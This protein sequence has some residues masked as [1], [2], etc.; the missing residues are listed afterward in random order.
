MGG[1][2]KWKKRVLAS[3]ETEGDRVT[4]NDWEEIASQQ[5]GVISRPSLKYEGQDR[6]EGAE[7]A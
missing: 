2:K 6:I 1:K 3:C 7:K 4:K 5:G